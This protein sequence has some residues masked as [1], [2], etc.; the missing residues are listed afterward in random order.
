MKK[1]EKASAKELMQ[2]QIQLKELRKI[3]HK[4]NKKSKMVQKGELPIEDIKPFFDKNQ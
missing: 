1:E 3:I 2:A 4:M